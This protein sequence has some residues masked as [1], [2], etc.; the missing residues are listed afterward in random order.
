[1]PRKEHHSTPTI[2]SRLLYTDTAAVSLDTSAWFAWLELHST[3]YF[4]SP[5]GTFTARC[6]QRA[7]AF[8]WYAFRR[9]HKRLY[10]VYLGKSSSLTSKRLLSVAQHLA[11]KAGA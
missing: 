7:D 8:F 1:M 2:I 6:E 9:Y 10:N 4:D 3:F 5:L 11:D